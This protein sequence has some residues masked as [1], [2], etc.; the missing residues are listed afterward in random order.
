[1]VR[2]LGCQTAPFVGRTRLPR[3]PLVG[4]QLVARRAGVMD[5]AGIAQVEQADGRVEGGDG[6]LDRAVYPAG[7]GRTR[8]GTSTGQPGDP[9]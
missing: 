6:G 4:R 3:R 5:G 9:S 1:M 2:L 7:E 8:A